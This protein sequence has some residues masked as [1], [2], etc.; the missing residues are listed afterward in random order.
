MLHL[1][2]GEKKVNF[3]KELTENILSFW[4]KDAIDYKNGGIYTQLDREG[5][6]YGRDKSVW[7]QGRALWVF[8]KAYNVIE[9]NPEYLKIAE[10]LYS[11]LPKCTDADGRMYF[12][13]TENGKGLQKRRYYYSETFAAI[14]CAEYYKATGDKG[15]M[16]DADKYFQVAY[17]CFKGIRYNP[18]K[19]NPQNSS[20]KS[21]APVMIMLSTAQVMRSM[22]S[23]K[24]DFYDSICTECVEEIVCGGYLTDKGLMENVNS[25]GT[26]SDT[27]TGRIVNPGHSMEAAWFVMSEGIIKGDQRLIDFGKNI[28]DITYPLGW[29]QKNGGLIAFTDVLGCPPVQLE[30]DMKLWWPQC[31]T[32]IA[33]RYAYMLFGDEKY[34]KIYEEVKEYCKKYFIDEKNGEWY[35]YL[36]YDNTPSTTLKGNIF[37]GPFHIPR[38]YILMSVLDET[39]DILQYLK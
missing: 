13:V 2:K 7:F 28:I 38:L 10:N 37:K 8:S 12:T 24:K 20:M 35:G 23:D 30:W 36:H 34:L 39:D 27:P 32:M 3:K 1:H 25:D 21:L 4:M 14:G 5:N 22:N 33:M 6:V 29:D 18:P 19:I 11:F 16:E 26:F 31:E 15:I 17:E 9:K